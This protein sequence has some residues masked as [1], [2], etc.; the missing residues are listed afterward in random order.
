ME[1]CLSYA[2]QGTQINTDRETALL[3]IPI[4]NMP[5]RGVSVPSQDIYRQG[6]APPPLY[7]FEVVLPNYLRN[8]VSFAAIAVF[9]CP[10]TLRPVAALR[11]IRIAF[12]TI[13]G[14]VLGID[15]L[16]FSLRLI[17][18]HQTLPILI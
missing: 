17:N 6:A 9:F 15:I 7:K 11:A 16:P 3:N 1:S 14:G 13:W 4:E 8:R 2:L 18:Q 12:Q 5:L 10:Q